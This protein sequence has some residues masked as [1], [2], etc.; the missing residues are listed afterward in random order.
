ESQPPELV[1][2][3]WPS[4][5]ELPARPAVFTLAVL[6]DGAGREFDRMRLPRELESVDVLPYPLL[7]NGL[8]RHTCTFLAS[9]SGLV[10]REAYLALGG[11]VLEYGIRSDLDMWLRIARQGPLGLLHEYLLHYR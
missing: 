5:G 8:L 7:F 6:M 3:H 9:P 11:H 2:G 10:R 4:L 1:R